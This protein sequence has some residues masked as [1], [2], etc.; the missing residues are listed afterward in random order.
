MN[1]GLENIVKNTPLPVAG[2]AFGIT[3]L[4]GYLLNLGK[5]TG[6]N[7]CLQHSVFLY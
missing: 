1:A 7:H 6:L 5:A 3:G 2:L 4:G